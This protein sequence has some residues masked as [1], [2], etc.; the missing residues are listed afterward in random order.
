MPL[1]SGFAFVG[2]QRHGSALRTL[3]EGENESTESKVL[4]E[5]SQAR[6]AAGPGGTTSGRSKRPPPA[7]GPSAPPQASPAEDEGTP[8]SCSAGSDLGTK[9]TSRTT[10]GF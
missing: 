5:A 10:P 1:L 2:A 7:A 9:R 3:L 4:S 6:I 8:R